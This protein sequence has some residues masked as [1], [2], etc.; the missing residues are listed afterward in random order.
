MR[1]SR[2]SVAPAGFG[3]VLPPV[4]LEFFGSANSTIV[5]PCLFLHHC[6]IKAGDGAGRPARWRLTSLP[7]RETRLIYPRLRRDVLHVV[8]HGVIMHRAIVDGGC[9][10]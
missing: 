5:L 4:I 2:V 3:Q 7:T 8:G 10:A 6:R 9:T 1:N